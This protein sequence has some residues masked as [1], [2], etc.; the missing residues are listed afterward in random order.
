VLNLGQYWLLWQ[1]IILIVFFK[2]IDSVKFNK[3]YCF[4][5]V[6]LWEMKNIR[7]V[8]GCLHALARYVGTL[9]DYV[10]IKNLS[11][12]KQE[13]NENEISETKKNT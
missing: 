3:I 12:V 2:A 13:F 7:N 6:D 1:Q 5:I 9:G 11:K 10:K 8:V 4:V